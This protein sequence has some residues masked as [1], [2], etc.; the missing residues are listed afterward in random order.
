MTCSF[1]EKVF[2][3]IVSLLLNMMMQCNDVGVIDVVTLCHG[4][5]F[6]ARGKMLLGRKLWILGRNFLNIWLLSDP[7]VFD[8]CKIE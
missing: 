8:N 2:K 4:S 5:N 3:Y 1:V 6:F 7:I